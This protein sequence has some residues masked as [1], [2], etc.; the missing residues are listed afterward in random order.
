[1]EEDRLLSNIPSGRDLFRVYFLAAQ[2]SLC[3]KPGAVPF[4]DSI[5]A[6]YA[7]PRSYVRGRRMPS[8][9]DCS[10]VESDITDDGRAG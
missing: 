6:T 10:G 4:G 2:G 7:L 1:M 3:H 5:P 9:R 8:L